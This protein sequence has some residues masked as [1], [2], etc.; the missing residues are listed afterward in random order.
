MRVDSVKAKTTIT[1]F[2]L[3]FFITKGEIAPF[4]Q[5]SIL[6][7]SGSTQVSLELTLQPAA[8]LL[9]VKTKMNVGRNKKRMRS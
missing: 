3:V 2:L 5:L 4:V 7:G 9:C 1:S 8:N 6:M